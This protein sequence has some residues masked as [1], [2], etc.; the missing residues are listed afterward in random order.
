[1]IFPCSWGL[2]RKNPPQIAVWIEDAQGRYLS[3]VYASSKIA[4]QSWLAAGGNRR[5]EALPHWCHSRGVQYAD[6]LYLP[7]KSEPLADGISGATP[8]GSFDLK[9]A[10]GGARSVRRKGRGEPFDRFQRNLS[11]IGQGGGARLLGRAARE[12]PAGRGL[13]RRRRPVV[14]QRGVRSRAGRP[15][16]S[17]RKF[18]R[19]RPRY[20]GAHFSAP[21]RGTHYD[22]CPM[23][24]RSRVLAAA[25]CVLPF[26]AA[27]VPAQELPRFFLFGVRRDGLRPDPPSSVPVVWRVTGHYNVSRR[28]SVGAGTGVSCYEKTLV[29]LFADAKFLLMRRRSFLRPMP[30][31]PPDMLSHRAGMPTGTAAQSRTGVQ[32][33]LRCGCT[34]SS[35]RAMSCCGWSGSGNTKAAGSPP[36][37]P[38]SSATAPSC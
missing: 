35:R 6:G 4:T 19:D 3:T 28:F 17:R 34:C 12:R 22:P 15:Q 16:Q 2:K 37:L 36:N 32:Y 14:G 13:C 1:M 20:F 27:E 18:G 8:R 33:A 25:L 31:A 5:R 10:R 26:L 30:G 23:T 11:R 21:D 9:L 29:P 38:S 24:G 7:T